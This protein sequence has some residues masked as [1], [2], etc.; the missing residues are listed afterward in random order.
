VY[1]LAEPALFVA[2]AWQIKYL[3]LTASSMDWV[4][5]NVE[6]LPIGFINELTDQD[7]P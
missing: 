6:P 5:V 7:V 2:V 3:P 1:P 4:M